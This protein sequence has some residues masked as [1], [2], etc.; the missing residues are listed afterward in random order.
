MFAR[1]SWVVGAS[2]AVLL[3]GSAGSCWAARI[4]YHF[5]PVNGGPALVLTPFVPGGAPG[6]R[7]SLLGRGEPFN[8]LPPRPTVQLT[9]THTITGR[10]LNVPLALPPDTPTIE[11][12]RNWL[13]YNYG[14]DAVEIHFL[15]DGSLDVIYST[16]LLRSP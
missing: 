1:K 14:S 5:V 10:P 7:L 15:E 9:L 6:E 8:C 12:R 2:V 3:L 4:R 16:G 13:Y 11:H